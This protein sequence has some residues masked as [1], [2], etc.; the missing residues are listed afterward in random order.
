MEVA[1]PVVAE[2]GHLACTWHG[3]II[4]PDSPGIYRNYPWVLSPLESMK[5][6]ALTSVPFCGT[7]VW[8]WERVAGTG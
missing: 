5:F 6:C 8:V 1:Q 7:C 2:P 3:I 4:G